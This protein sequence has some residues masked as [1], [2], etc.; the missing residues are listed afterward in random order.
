MAGA[1][2][3]THD[4]A[5]ANRYWAICAAAGLS[6][7][8]TGYAPS[9]FANCA[10]WGCRPTPG[11]TDI[12]GNYWGSSSDV[13]DGIAAA[14]NWTDYNILI[15]AYNN[16]YPWAYPNDATIGPDS[17][18]YPVCI[19]EHPVSV[20]NSGSILNA[21]GQNFTL[22][23]MVGATGFTGDAAGAS[24]YQAICAAA[25]LSTLGSGFSADF[26]G[27]CEP[28]GCLPT[29][30]SPDNAGNDWG[31]SAPSTPPRVVAITGFTG[32][33]LIHGSTGFP[34]ASQGG[35]GVNPRYT[36]YPICIESDIPT[37]N[38]EAVVEA[39]VE[40]TWNSGSITNFNGQ[41]FTLYR[42]AGA[43]G[44]T[45]D[46]AGAN[47]Y[48]AICAAAGLHTLGPG[49]AA[50]YFANCAPWGCMPT[51]GPN[52]NAIWGSTSNVD[53]AIASVANWTDYNILIHAYN[54]GFPFAYPDDATIGR[55]SIYY[56]ATSTMESRL[57][58]TGRTTTY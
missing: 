28:W 19:A 48:W 6:T 12:A 26:Y 21:V 42:M 3:F 49:Y 31:T 45:H 46:A 2:G 58:P 41:P 8:G 33:V 35:F 34:F 56:P 10:Q 22:Y 17:I 4:T 38:A 18:Y 32:N 13:D 57:P 30:A 44:F 16:G 23:K 54:N 25:G 50:S 15:H 9:Y 20:W 7:L 11:G 47:R 27:A 53:D 29:P 5:G 37:N 1:T 24:L 39:T 40:A 43:T 51:P 52:M 14:T 55:D 36:Y